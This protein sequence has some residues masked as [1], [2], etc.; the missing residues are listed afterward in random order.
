MCRG[1]DYHRLYR[2]R[3]R[4]RSQN[5]AI[6][7]CPENEVEAEQEY[8]TGSD[9]EFLSKAAK[10]LTL[11]HVETIEIGT[12]AKVKKISEAEWNATVCV[13]IGGIPALM[14]PDSGSFGNILDEKQYRAL[15]KAGCQMSELRQPRTGIKTIQTELHAIGEFNAVISNSQAR[16]L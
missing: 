10:H 14:E 5:A 8:G 3:G 6:R 12:S 1:G 15:K 16:A 7:R 2:S 9:D 4:G 11:K 13:E